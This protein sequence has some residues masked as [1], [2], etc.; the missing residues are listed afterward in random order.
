M[1]ALQHYPVDISDQYNLSPI[2]TPYLV[3]DDNLRLRMEH[4]PSLSD[5][6]YR[7]IL[8]AHIACFYPAN[9]PEMTRHIQTMTREKLAITTL[10]KGALAEEFDEHMSTTPEFLPPEWIDLS[11]II[12]HQTQP[13]IKH[14]KTP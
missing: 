4:R 14:H 7:D 9:L 6:D 11:P 1:S 12:E 3:V 13:P 8:N 5:E 10:Y 2:D